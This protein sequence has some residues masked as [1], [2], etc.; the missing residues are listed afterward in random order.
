MEIDI[1]GLPL[2]HPIMNAAG[3]CKMFAGKEG[4]EELARSATSAVVL[5]SITMA[6]RDGNPGTTFYVDPDGRFSL[7]SLGLPNRGLAWYREL[8]PAV[9]RTCRAAGKPL[10]VSVAGFSPKEY[11]MLAA[12]AFEGGADMVELNGGCPNVWDGREQKRIPS[13]D[14]AM[15]CDILMHVQDAVGPDARVTVKLSPMSDPHALAALAKTVTLWPVVKGVVTS[16]TFPNTFARDGK[17]AAIS[18]GSGLAGMAGPALKPIA[19]GQVRQ[20][21]ALLPPSIAVIG[22]GGIGT[23]GDVRDFIA[24][25][26]TAVQIGTALLRHGP[27][28]FERLI[29]EFMN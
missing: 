9:W 10:I 1:Y 4:V 16:N 17:A 7:N 11:A 3:T 28:I 13:F 22:V 19:L 5:G 29:E 2:Q 8:F 23:G 14:T 26:A 20:L 25:G 15:M 24:A 21:R 12:A 27:R 6:H 18:V